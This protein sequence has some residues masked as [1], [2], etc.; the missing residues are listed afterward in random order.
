MGNLIPYNYNQPFPW[1]LIDTITYMVDVSLPMD[2]MIKLAK[3][4]NLIWIDHHKSAIADYE[5]V[6]DQFPLNF[7]KFL[8]DG[9]AACE[10]C[11]EFC[12]KK[13]IYPMA[14]HL[15]G[16]YDVWKHE[17]VPGT[18]EFQYGLRNKDAEA[19]DP[20]W[21][22]LFLGNE[23][24]SDIIVE[25]RILLDYEARQSKKYMGVTA[26]EHE[27][28]G[29][30]CICSNK[31]L[32]NS[33]VFDSIYDPMIHD[34]MLSFYMG[35]RGTWYVSLY[36]TRADVDCSIVAKQWGGGGHKGAAG[37]QVDDIGKLFKQGMISCNDALPD[38]LGSDEWSRPV[39]FTVEDKDYYGRFSCNGWFFCDDPNSLLRM[40]LGKPLPPNGGALDRDVA[41]HWRY[42]Q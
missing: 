22:L 29:L 8:R 35:K 37:F 34:A 30:Q 20:I 27:F 36:S 16:R 2:D 6:A 10:L 41:T 1:D 26:F 11:W 14:V 12:A 15:L 24:V 13:D 23:L 28:C 33:L 19:G 32:T 5:A 40:A 9:S 31:G 42:F 4:T 3:M 39:I 21:T 7:T 18:L 17:D 38:T 25:G